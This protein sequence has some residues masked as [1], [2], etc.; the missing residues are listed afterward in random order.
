LDEEGFGDVSSARLVESFA[1]HLM[2]HIDAAQERGFAAVAEE[3]LPRLAPEKGV[4]RDIDDNGDLL[5]RRVGDTAVERR[6]L[7]PALV[8]PSW[9]DPA[10]QGPRR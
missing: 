2:V 3:Y 5:V 6:P 8:T 1:R 4:R 10:T 7:I 9:L